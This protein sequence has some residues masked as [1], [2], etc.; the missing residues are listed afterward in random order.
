MNKHPEL[1]HGPPFN[2]NSTLGIA[3]A[4]ADKAALLIDKQV[5]AIGALP[6]QVLGQ[7]VVLQSG[8]A[9]VTG[10]VLFQNAGN[11]IG[12]GENRLTFFPG[13][14]WTADTAELPYYLGNIY[15][16]P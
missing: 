4:R 1:V 11:G 5:T 16:R 6:S 10:G 2:F 9:I 7:A 3:A 12:T 13:N 14:G 8:L 15:L